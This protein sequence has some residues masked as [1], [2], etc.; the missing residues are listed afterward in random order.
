MVKPCSRVLLSSALSSSGRKI[1]KQFN[2]CRI[3]AVDKQN[4]MHI[5]SFVVKWV[6]TKVPLK[7]V[8]LHIY[9]RKEN[10]NNCQRLLLQLHVGLLHYFKFSQ[11]HTACVERT[12]HDYYLRILHIFDHCANL[13][14][15]NDNIYLLMATVT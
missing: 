3:F 5:N 4:K 10:T 11:T 8:T 7:K 6:H 9:F 14:L 13:L 15:H 2:N 12:E 1:A